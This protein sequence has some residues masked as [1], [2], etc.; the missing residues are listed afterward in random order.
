MKM[1]IIKYLFKPNWNNVNHKKKKRGLGGRLNGKKT[2]YR[3]LL[4]SSNLVK[5]RFIN[6]K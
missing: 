5:I 3:Y 2:I 1:E 6:S 4:K